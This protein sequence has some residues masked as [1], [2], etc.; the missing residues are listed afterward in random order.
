MDPSDSRAFTVEVSLDEAWL[1][2]DVLSTPIWDQELLAWLDHPQ[3]R[4][5]RDQIGF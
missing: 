3:V 4:D 2:D 1:L 5:L